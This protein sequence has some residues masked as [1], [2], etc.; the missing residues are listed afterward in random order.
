LLSDPP[1]SLT[2]PHLEAIEW[3]DERVDVIWPVLR[4]GASEVEQTATIH[5]RRAAAAAM[6]SRHQPKQREVRL[7]QRLR[8]GRETLH[9]QAMR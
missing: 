1:R 4:I 9:R 5:K 2:T 6:G 3:L 7:I 8:I